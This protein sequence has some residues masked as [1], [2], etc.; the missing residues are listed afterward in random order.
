MICTDEVDRLIDIAFDE[1]FAQSAD[2]TT[3]AIFP[4][5]M[6]NGTYILKAKDNGILCG[7]QIVEMVFKKLDSSLKVDFMH[8]DGDFISYGDVVA[9]IE[10]KIASILKGE[11][12]A[13][14]FICYLSAI[15]TRTNEFVK[16]A[17]PVKIL[18]TRKTLPGYRRLAKYAVA[19]GGAV[20]HRMGLY[21]MVMIKDNHIDGAGSI[22]QA[23]KLVREKW[24]NRYK[25]EAETRNLTEVE[26]ALRLDVDRIMLDN[27]DNQTIMKAVKMINGK[28][29]IEASGNMTLERVK[30]LADSGI[31]YI[32]VG[33]LTHSVTVFDFSLVS[34][35]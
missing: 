4:D 11:R 29:E 9:E 25:I 17:S 24:G 28:K 8:S 27:M 26:E 32:S 14:N 30:T 18:D 10:G 22:A 15:A 1:D 7:T 5:G 13:L 16:A 6:G 21:D 31:D 3:D 33:E 34:G 19:C 12:T 35:K 20:N 23:V 2:V